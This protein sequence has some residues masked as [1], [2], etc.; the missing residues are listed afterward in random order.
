VLSRHYGLGQTPQTLGEIGDG[1]GITAERVRQIE[2]EAL[3]KLRAA[4]AQPPIPP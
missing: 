3:T 2:A 1:L 4:A